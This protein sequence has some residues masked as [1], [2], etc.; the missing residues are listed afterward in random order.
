MQ[1][2]SLSVRGFR[3]LAALDTDLAPGS[4]IFFGPNGSGKTNLLEAIFSLLLGRSQRGAAD[5][6]MLAGGSSVYRLEGQV[7]VDGETMQLAVAYRQ[8]ERKKITIESVRIRPA[9]LYER[10][11]VV[12]SGPEDSRILSGPPSL[13]R[14]FVDV[15]LSQLSPRYLASLVEY[16]RALTQKNAALKA[17][18]DASPFE[19]LLISHGVAVIEKRRD[20][21]GALSER[22]SEHY[23][24]V[25]G[26]EAMAMAYEPSVPLSDAADSPEALSGEFS[27]KL[28]RYRERELTVRTALV[29]PH[30]DEV[31]FEINNLPAR[32]H[33][34]QGQW[35][36]AAIALKL[37][38]YDLLQEGRGQPP[39]LLLDEIFAELDRGR[40][41]S[42]IGSFAG[43]SQL[44]LTTAVEPPEELRR[45]GRSYRIENGRIEDVK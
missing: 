15:Y 21:L 9:E 44:F 20:F 23:R 25:S 22:V 1:L 32:T 35:R 40:T 14:N 24:K 2:N 17:Q 19:A 3:N 36:T 30:R 4:N 29:G 6:V 41:L 33:G 39:I 34:S 12:S 37:A 45:N 28:A 43:F 26:G 31:R 10:F 16:Q 8:N 13:R 5:S 7:Q 38:I 27:K 18:M 42:L 11:C